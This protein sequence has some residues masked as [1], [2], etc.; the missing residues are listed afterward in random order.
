[1]NQSNY[2]KSKEYQ[3]QYRDLHKIRIYWLQFYVSSVQFESSLAHTTT[4]QTRDI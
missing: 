4:N 2:L 1:M 3:E